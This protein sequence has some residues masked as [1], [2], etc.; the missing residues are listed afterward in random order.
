MSVLCNYFFN[1]HSRSWL[2]G[3]ALQGFGA[4]ESRAGEAGKPGSWETEEERC[5]IFR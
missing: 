3:P 2:A 4:G 1:N 5:A